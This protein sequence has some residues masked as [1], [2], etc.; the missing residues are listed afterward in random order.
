LRIEVRIIGIKV[1]IIRIERGTNNRDRG[2]NS[3]RRRFAIPDFDENE[4]EESD[5]DDP[6]NCPMFNGG[7]DLQ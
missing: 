2:A 7:D 1:R 6:D 3:L 4:E 5:A